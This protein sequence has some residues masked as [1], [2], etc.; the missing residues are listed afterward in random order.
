MRRSPGGPPTG[1]SAAAHGGPGDRRPAACRGP[2]P[3]GAHPGRAALAP[4]RRRPPGRLRAAGD[5]AHQHLVVAPPAP[6]GGL[7][8]GGPAGHHQGAEHRS[9]SR[10]ALDRALASLTPR[11]R[12]VIVLRYYEDLTE[13]ATADALGVATGTVK[14]QTHLALRR[15]R[16]LAPPRR[17]AGGL[18]MRD[19][20][21]HDL[22]HE[23]VADLTMPTSPSGPGAG[24][25]A[26]GAGVRR[27]RSRSVAAV[28]VTAVAVNGGAGPLRSDGPLP[29]ASQVPT[30]DLSTG[31]TTGPSTGPPPGRTPDRTR[32]GRG[33]RPHPTVATAAGG[34]TGARSSTRSRRCRAPPRR[35]RTPST[36]PRPRRT[37]RTGRSP[38]RWPPT[39]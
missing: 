7:R 18:P 9:E 28:V 26:S 22:L 17:D 8:R 11:Q 39:P 36:C 29:P 35:S 37:W 31:P 19:Q 16:H 30:P 14:S 13:R 25:A 20:E 2:G 27:P 33:R 21:L 24:P 4:A 5:R 23:R 38:R 32:R 6:R 34:S 1:S 10:L 15:A 12:A 3:G